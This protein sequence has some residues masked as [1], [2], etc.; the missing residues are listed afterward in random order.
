MG[1]VQGP[2][3]EL[4]ISPLLGDAGGMLGRGYV[5][6]LLI[7]ITGVGVEKITGGGGPGVL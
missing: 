5:G 2:E 7:L 3:L 6:Y 1:A 4:V